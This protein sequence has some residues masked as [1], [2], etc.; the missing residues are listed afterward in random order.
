ML[1]LLYILLRFRGIIKKRTEKFIALLRKSP[2]LLLVPFFP[3]HFELRG[4]YKE[5]SKY[6]A[7]ALLIWLCMS[8]VLAILLTSWTPLAWIE[9]SITCFATYGIPT[10]LTYIITIV[11]WWNKGIAPSKYRTQNITNS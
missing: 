2:Q 7:L 10:V 8:C 6:T 11:F 4:R 3:R 9:T 1:A 5:Y